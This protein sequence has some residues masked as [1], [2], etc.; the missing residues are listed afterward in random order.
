[1]Q[2]VMS[3]TYTGGFKVNTTTQDICNSQKKNETNM[4]HTHTHTHKD[5][6]FTLLKVLQM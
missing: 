5:K 3:S 4:T 1:M 2:I 6:I